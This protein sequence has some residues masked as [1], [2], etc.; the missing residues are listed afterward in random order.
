MLQ[1]RAA[2]RERLKAEAASLFAVHKGKYGAARITA[3]LEGAG[4][5][6]SENTVAALLREQH[7]AAGQTAAQ[8]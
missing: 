7:L 3:G 2:R 1:P 5:R 8:G 6:V 4:W